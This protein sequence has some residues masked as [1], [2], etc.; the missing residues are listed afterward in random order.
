MKKLTQEELIA[1]INKLKVEGQVDLSL[2][3]D[4][5]IAV[6]N[7]IGLEEHFFFTAQKT[8]KDEYLDL[9]NQTRQMRK[10]LLGRMINKN[11]GETWCICKHLLATTM[12]LMEVGTKLLSDKKDSEAQDMFKKAYEIYLMFWGLRLKL[13]DLPDLKTTDA[14]EAMTQDEILS[15]L[16]D[17][18]KE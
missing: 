8:G 9:L 12:R 2:E 15:R 17:C 10:E 11:E 6:M 18:C 1:K 16:L 13:I 3:E 7:L 14:D 5:S 4:L